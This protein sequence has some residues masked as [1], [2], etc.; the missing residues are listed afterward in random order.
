MAT[1]DLE[2]AVRFSDRLWLLGSHG[3]IAEGSPPELL[4]NGVI[5]RFFDKNNI[6]LNREKIIFEKKLKNVNQ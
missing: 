6:I 2:A 3:E 5:N 4:E 1:H